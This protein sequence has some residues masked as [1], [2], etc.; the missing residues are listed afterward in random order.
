LL[1]RSINEVEL[2]NIWAPIDKLE[3][4]DIVRVEWKFVTADE[5]VQSMLAH[6]RKRIEVSFDSNGD[7]QVRFLDLLGVRCSFR[8]VLNASFGKM[9]VARVKWN[10]FGVCGHL[11]PRR[12]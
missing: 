2:L 8:W 5:N 11:V 12:S 10:D 9:F 4:R 1:R 3:I 6:E 7:A